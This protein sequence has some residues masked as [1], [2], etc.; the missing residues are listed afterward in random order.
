MRFTAR[1][2]RDQ[3]SH[4]QSHNNGRRGASTLLLPL[5]IAAAVSV[6]ACGSEATT[7]QS[8]S[9]PADSSADQVAADTGDEGETEPE[10]PSD[11]TEPTG[12][13]S[14]EPDQQQ[15]DADDQS[16]GDDQ[17]EPVSA[18]VGDPIPEGATVEQIKAVM[19]DAHG[20]TTNVA[21]QVNRVAP[22]PDVPTPL[23]ADLRDMNARIS[24]SLDNRTRWVGVT[25]LAPGTVDDLVTFYETNLAP[26]NW[27]L[28]SETDRTESGNLQRVFEY[29]YD[30]SGSR[31]DTFKVTLTET[32]DGGTE[33][34]LEERVSATTAEMTDLDSRLASWRG[35][36]PI[37]EG[38]EVY[39]WEIRSSKYTG[40]KLQLAV[41]QA[42]LG[43]G[44]AE[45]L[46]YVTDSLPTA[47]YSIDS[48]RMSQNSPPDG[49]LY[50]QSD[51]FEEVTFRVSEIDLSSG[52]TGFV[53][54]EGDL[55]FNPAN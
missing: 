11:S 1:A 2:N 33:V 17:Q 41:R 3:N 13:D 46:K 43:Q 7:I 10:A 18:P 16:T 25:L 14:D 54:I 9:A 48:E 52:L 6:T 55:D 47:N 30:G 27:S 23:G 50:G 21:G 5:L 29:E 34:N 20:P 32:D 51:M 15:P 22:F 12:S 53:E 24:S 37:P 45:L 28:V 19:E 38:G 40:Y 26:F 31:D 4:L 39:E 36:A 8:Q 49:W 42:Y 35:E 44:E